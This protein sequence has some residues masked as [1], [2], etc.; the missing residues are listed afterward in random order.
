MKYLYNKRMIG[1]LIVFLFL[2]QPIMAQEEIENQYRIEVNS[3]EIQEEEENPD[4]TAIPTPVPALL[5]P[6]NSHAVFEEQGYV[7]LS[8]GYASSDFRLSLSQSSVSLGEVVTGQQASASLRVSVLSEVQTPYAVYTHL[9]SHLKTTRNMYIIRTKCDSSQTPC[10]L[11]NAQEW[12]N[13]DSYGLG[14]TVTGN[15]VLPDFVNNTYFRSFPHSDAQEKPRLI[16]EGLSGTV[17][18]TSTMEIKIQYP[19]T[20]PEGSYTSG[21]HI[22]AIPE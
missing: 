8:D 4:P 19:K 2:G 22:I 9:D 13:T 16:I 3:I 11:S 5:I 1:G 18:E 21:L 17:P 12:T 10:T 15:S 20:Q 6:Q 14:Y 7:I